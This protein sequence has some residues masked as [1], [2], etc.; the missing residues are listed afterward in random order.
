MSKLK[1]GC[2]LFYTLFACSI[3]VVCIIYLTIPQRNVHGFKL[4]ERRRKLH[5][6]D[7][8][9]PRERRID[10]K[11]KAREKTLSSQ[12]TWNNQAINVALVEKLKFT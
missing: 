10:I 9:L 5:S 11:Q 4:N 6:I 1:D 2:I 12:E 7:T 3:C 8:L